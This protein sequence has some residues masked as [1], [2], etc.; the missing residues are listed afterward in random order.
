MITINTFQYGTDNCGRAKA[1]ITGKP[2]NIP[3]RSVYNLEKRK[4][5]FDDM[6]LQRLG[7]KALKCDLLEIINFIRQNDPLCYY[8]PNKQ[9][10]KSEI[11]DWII[12][13]L[14][15]YFVVIDSIQDK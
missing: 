4:K 10:K 3:K 11:Y 12:E 6:C 2:I 5:L 1:L 7:R 14:D 9:T 8:E 13:N 15:K